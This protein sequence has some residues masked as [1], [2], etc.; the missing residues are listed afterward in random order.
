M[1]KLRRWTSG[2]ANAMLAG[3]FFWVVVLRVAE[4]QPLLHL[5]LFGALHGLAVLL[6][7][8]LFAVR[9]WGLAV[10]G[11]LCGPLPL[12]VLTQPSAAKADEWGGAVMAGMLLGVLIGLLEWA[13][14]S[15]VEADVK[16]G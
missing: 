9:S 4:P 1:R 2:W 12:A 13:R 7:M 16:R 8:R 10:A 14:L 6:L 15:R 5:A 3:C 11:V